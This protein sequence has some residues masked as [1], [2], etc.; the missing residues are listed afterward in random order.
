[1]ARTD[2]TDL[3]LIRHASKDA[4]YTNAER[5]VVGPKGIKAAKRYRS[6]KNRRRTEP[7]TKMSGY[8]WGY[9]NYRYCFAD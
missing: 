2:K 9:E 5:L 7:L 1:M 8:G 3:Y 4:G 6:K